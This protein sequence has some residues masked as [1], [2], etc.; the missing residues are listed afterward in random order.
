MR[1]CVFYLSVDS[2]SVKY[3]VHN[4]KVLGLRHVCHCNVRNILSFLKG[5]THLRPL[6]IKSHAPT[7]SGSRVITIKPKAKVDIRMAAML[8]YILQQSHMNRIMIFFRHLLTRVFRNVH[9]LLTF[10]VP[11]Y[12]MLTCCCY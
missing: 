4:L 1:I 11:V 12:G 6:C 5:S 2:V 8:F 10:H 3:I 7:S 9:Q